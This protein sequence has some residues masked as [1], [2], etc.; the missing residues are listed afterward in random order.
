MD[1]AQSGHR[2]RVPE[3]RQASARAAGRHAEERRHPG[4]HADHRV[5][6]G[7]ASGAVDSS[8]R[9]G[10]QVY[11][12]AARGV[13]RRMG[14]Q[15]DVPLSLGARGGHSLGRR[16]YRALDDAGSGRGAARQRDRDGARA[17]GPARFFRRLESQRPRRKSRS[18]SATRSRFS[19]LISPI[20]RTCSAGVPR[21]P[22]SRCGGSSTTRGPIRRRA[23]SSMRPRPTCSH[24]S[25]GCC[26]RGPK[27]TSSR[28][29]VSRPA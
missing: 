23:R 15:V 3:V 17:H 21:L 11:F 2:R 24:G 22:T 13:R 6:R 28:G 29:R 1:S 14:Q 19:S 10:Y 16:A 20:V 7:A 9:S 5:R 25:I 12:G 8:G 27:A 26:G 18:H 4:F